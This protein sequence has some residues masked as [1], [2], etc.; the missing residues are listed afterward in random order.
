MFL[1]KILYLSALLLILVPLIISLPY[2]HHDVQKRSSFFDIDC[3][4][5]F[6]KSIFFRLDRICEDCYSLFREVELHALCKKQCFT[7]EFFKGCLE[8]LQLHDE[9]NVIKSYIKV[10]N[11]ADPHLGN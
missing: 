3:K 5:V 2:Q 8:A 10:V 6:N 4:G 9:V 7:T 1:C 11:G